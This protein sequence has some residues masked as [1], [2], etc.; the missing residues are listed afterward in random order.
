MGV[1]K[2]GPWM[3][4][5]GSRRQINN[6]NLF[7]VY[8]CEL[9]WM[10]RVLFLYASLPSF[11]VFST[12]NKIICSGSPSS[13]RMMTSPSP[14]LSAASSKNLYFRTENS[15]HLPTATS[16][17]ESRNF[18]NNCSPSPHMNSILPGTSKNKYI[19]LMWMMLEGET[20]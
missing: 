8:W 4:M 20:L 12:V 17:S 19:W 6:K 5:F 14:T 11:Y 1:K 10:S 15:I 3:F 2:C 9:S 13:Q 16:S 7:V 18:S